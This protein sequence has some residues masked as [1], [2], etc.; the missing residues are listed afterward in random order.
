[1]AENGKSRPDYTDDEMMIV[2]FAREIT[3]GDIL[4]QGVGAM[5]SAAGYML[6]K[7]THAP[8]A[9]LNFGVGNVMVLEAFPL[10]LLYLE[11]DALRRGF[12]QY[13]MGEAMAELTSCWSSSILEFLRPA[14]VD[15]YGNFNNTVIGSYERPKVRL[16][17]GAG[18]PDIT[19]T[20]RKGL[21]LYTPRHDRRTFVKKLDFVTGAGFLRGES[22]EERH[23]LGLTGLGPVRM[24]TNLGVFGFD[25]ASR[26]MM[27]L[28]VHPGATPEDIRQNTEFDMLIPPGAPPTEPPTPEELRLI[29]E[30]VDPLGLRKLEVLPSGKD[31]DALI[32]GIMEEEL[33]GRTGSKS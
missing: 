17:G 22:D 9:V 20:R 18:I 10:S 6:A 23:R 16:P 5:M 27:V 11:R 26:R 15:M 3:D 12:F 14:Q 13:G 4:V 33:R 21:Y 24:I 31:R 25:G 19:G 29:R 8:H 7:M 2:C 30:E 28:S 32:R 1:M